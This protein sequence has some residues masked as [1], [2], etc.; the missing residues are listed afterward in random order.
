MKRKSRRTLALIFFVGIAAVPVALAIVV[1]GISTGGT[2]SR[3]IAQ[4][5]GGILDMKVVIDG[6]RTSSPTSFSLEG[7]RITPRGAPEPLAVFQDVQL[8]FDRDAGTA[9]FVIEGGTFQLGSGAGRRH[10]ADALGR[11]MRKKDYLDVT[12]SVKDLAVELPNGGTAL[13]VR[14]GKGIRLQA[15]EA[16]KLS[17]TLENATADFQDELMTIKADAALVPRGELPYSVTASRSARDVLPEAIGEILGEVRA[18]CIRSF[19]D[20]WETLSITGD[21][22][23][24]S[25]RGTLSMS[26]LPV[27]D[28]LGL[29]D[30]DTYNAIETPLNALVLRDG[31]VAELELVIR[32]D[33]LQ[34]GKS[35][36]SPASGRLLRTIV[37]LG[38]GG[39]MELPFDQK[40]FQFDDLEFEVSVKDDGV[41]LIGNFPR[42]HQGQWIALAGESADVKV[43]ELAGEP[44]TRE[45]FAARWKEVIKRNQEGW[46][47]ET[48]SIEP[49]DVPNVI[50]I[51]RRLGGAGREAP[52]E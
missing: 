44:V 26:L 41:R 21:S 3:T 10:T 51:F 24:R 1:V 12:C 36:L 49:V 23:D 42:R 8:D 45:E 6:V 14:E 25:F 32:H 48:P 35:A 27:Y 28:E 15:D 40:R 47:G 22:V 29:A 37:Y 2:L 52:E 46:P 50:D 17:F 34:L 19:D 33:V 9:A 18:R 13:E 38:T 43:A 4:D 16:G 39:E 11:L 5:L 7:I 31:A 20:G 30:M